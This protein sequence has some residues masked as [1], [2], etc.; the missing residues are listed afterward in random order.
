MIALFQTRWLS[1]RQ[2]PG[3]A[4]AFGLIV[5]PLSLAAAQSAPTS[6]AVSESLLEALQADDDAAIDE[7]LNQWLAP[8]VAA[9]GNLDTRPADQQRRAVVVLRR[10]NANLRYQVQRAMLS[11]DDQ[12]RL[13]RVF[14]SERRLIE[15]LFDEDDRVRS[16]AI[17]RIPLE[18]NTAAG[19][20]LAAKLFDSNAEVVSAAIEKIRALHD[21]ASLRGLRQ[22]AREA[23]RLVRSA[24]AA[25]QQDPLSTIV[26]VSFLDHAGAIFAAHGIADD[27]KLLNEILLLLAEPG[28]SRF[29]T[30][31]WAILDGAGR[32]AGEDAVEGV[33]RYLATPDVQ[34]LPSLPGGE[35]VTRT[36]A[37]AALRALARIY[38]I[39]PGALGF[40]GG[41]EGAALGFKDHSIRQRAARAFDDWFVRN[42]QR[43]KA[44]REP[45][46]PIGETESRP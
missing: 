1:R 40:V 9:I 45:F 4:V 44:Q 23:S 24:P 37:D 29:A 41:A 11:P 39:D 2:R 10:I 22:F 27:A 25:E 6:Q 20:L 13:D 38:G 36:T 7:F 5:S 21:E 17:D 3:L 19:I 14:R 16:A 12:S 34:T 33:S 32:L 26:Y 43:P 35:R 30:N 8:A 28:Y 15:A 18:P 42:R 31:T 46:R